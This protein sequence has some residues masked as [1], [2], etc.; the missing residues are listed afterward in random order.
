MYLEHV[1]PDADGVFHL[2]PTNS[3]EYPAQKLGGDA[4][5]DLAL[6]KWGLTTLL[7][8]GASSALPSPD[9]SGVGAAPATLATE[10]ELS[11]WRSVL[12]HLTSGPTD[13][14]GYMVS[15]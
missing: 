2:P 7:A 1:Y 15:V 14:H 3:P 9:S 8:L 5:Y 11:L 12:T 13:A 10:R 4:N 6:L